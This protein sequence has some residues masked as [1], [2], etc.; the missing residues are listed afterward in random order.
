MK[1]LWTLI[2]SSPIYKI[3]AALVIALSLFAIVNIVG[4]CTP[5]NE[6][7]E[8]DV[9]I[10]L[11]IDS[12]KEQHANELIAHEDSIQKIA[13]SNIA[14]LQSEKDKEAA[15]TK[16]LE[17]KLSDL[18]KSVAELE[19]EYAEQC[20]ELITT[21][22]ERHDTAMSIIKQKSVELKICNNEVNTY[23]SIARSQDVEITALKSTVKE[24]NKTI[25]TQRDRLT[26]ITNRSDRNFIFRNWKWVTGRWREFVLE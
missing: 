17:R 25:G 13:Y 26:S 15:K 3:F 5:G 19:K 18:N 4:N 12:I 14:L 10:Q 2:K 20:G 8:Q 24:K 9:A 16:K 22:R 11:A 23:T 21:Y 7:S 1:T 6:P